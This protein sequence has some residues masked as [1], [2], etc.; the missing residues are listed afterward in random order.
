LKTIIEALKHKTLY[1]VSIRPLARDRDQA[2][3]NAIT[4]NPKPMDSIPDVLNGEAVYD[5][6]SWKITP[7]KPGKVVIPLEVVDHLFT[8]GLR[9]SKPKKIHF[10]GAFCQN[11]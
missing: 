8:Q 1:D 2:P 6:A 7:V 5:R 9:M 3:A 4:F 10:W 11:L